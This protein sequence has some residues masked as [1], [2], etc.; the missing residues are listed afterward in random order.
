MSGGENQGQIDHLSGEILEIFARGL[1]ALLLDEV[2]GLG[3]RGHHLV[4]NSI[5]F[6]QTVQR[7]F[8]QSI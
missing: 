8:Q 6:Q 7:D 1:H 4:V 5:E 3:E 2:C